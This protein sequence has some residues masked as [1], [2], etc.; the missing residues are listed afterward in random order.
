MSNFLEYR[1]HLEYKRTLQAVLRSYQA[2]EFAE[3]TGGDDD[4]PESQLEQLP[5]DQLE[6]NGYV[7]SQAIKEAVDLTPTDTLVKFTDTKNKIT[8]I[9]GQ[10]VE[11]LRKDVTVLPS[12]DE[13]IKAREENDTDII[14]EFEDFHSDN[15]EGSTAAEVLPILIDLGEE[16]EYLGEFLGEQ[17]FPD[18]LTQDLD[19]LDEQLDRLQ[20]E[21]EA[22]MTE[23]IEQD[24]NSE[25][26]EDLL[27]EENHI[28]HFLAERADT[29]GDFVEEV[30]ALITATLENIYYESGKK[31]AELITSQ[32]TFK[33]EIS[34]LN[35]RRFNKQ[36]KNTADAARRMKRLVNKEYKRLLLENT[37]ALQQE[38]LASKAALTA[39]YGANPEAEDDPMNLF[40]M[41]MVEGIR[42]MKEE[43]DA[44]VEDLYRITELEVYQNNDYLTSLEQKNTTRQMYTIMDK[45]DGIDNNTVNVDKEIEKVFQ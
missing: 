39:F 29:V 16:I 12:V 33:T 40:F 36:K 23:L 4:Q 8:T 1:P 34:K 19:Y 45:L 26:D 30:E 44:L 15:I 32:S 9:V 43:A 14:Y 10:I 18:E 25:L 41:D 5:S 17:F 2:D 28:L 37:V 3:F 21:E 6:K 24:V 31:I 38:K 13:Y 42:D 11:N 35:L 7:P 20:N 22:K 27:K